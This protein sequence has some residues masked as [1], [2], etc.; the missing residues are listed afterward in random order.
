MFRF[1]R[2]TFCDRID[3]DCKRLN[4]ALADLEHNNVLHKVQ[5][6]IDILFVLG[7]NVSIGSLANLTVCRELPVSQTVADSQPDSESLVIP[8]TVCLVTAVTL[9]II[10]LSCLL[11]VFRYTSETQLN[12]DFNS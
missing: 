11:L 8:V 12:I 10:T 9:C 7:K 1:F 4:T 2:K 3:F 6:L 5:H